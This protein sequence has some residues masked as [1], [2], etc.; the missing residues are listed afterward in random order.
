LFR[1]AGYEREN[2]V[3]LK[4]TVYEDMFKDGLIN[5]RCRCYL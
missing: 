3:S 2:A 1:L 4:K 5:F